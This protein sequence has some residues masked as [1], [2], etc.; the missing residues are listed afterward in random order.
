MIF[1]VLAALVILISI[2]MFI[3]KVVLKGRMA[4]GLGRKVNDRE[5]TSLTAWMAT[6]DKFEK[7]SNV[8]GK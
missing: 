5:L 6:S 7:K 4:R 2:V 3:Q 8:E 1:I